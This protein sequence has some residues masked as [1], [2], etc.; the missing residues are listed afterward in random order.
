MT[1]NQAIAYNLQ[2]ARAMRDL[3]Q[4]EAAERIQRYLGG[5]TWSKANLSAAER[6]VTGKRVRQFSADEIMAFARA[7]DLD[8]GFFFQPPL[9]QDPFHRWPAVVSPPDAPPERLV[10]DVDLAAQLVPRNPDEWI[11]RVVR[12]VEQA[13]KP[14]RDQ[15]LR[16]LEDLYSR[17]SAWTDGRE[18]QRAADATREENH[19]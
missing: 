2:L 15:I 18:R 3:T 7:F 14:T 6:S 8:V 1:T 19:D 9:G 11:Q 4:E 10:S 12:G 17:L 13:D 5:E 16:G